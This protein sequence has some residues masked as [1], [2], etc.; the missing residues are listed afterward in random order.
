MITI[1]PLTKADAE[2]YREIRLEMLESAP[3]AFSSDYEQNKRSSLR[4]FANRIQTDE[5]NFIIGAFVNSK[6]VGTGGF[7]RE[8]SRKLRHR[9]HV[10]GV[11]VK[12]EERGQG[13]ARKICQELI[14]RVGR[15]D[16]L[17]QI[18]IA[19][20]STNQAAKRLYES[21]G[22]VAYG[23]APKALKIEDKY[24]DEDLMV[25]FLDEARGPGSGP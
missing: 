3:E 24:H 20:T 17:E 4:D 18:H 10:W 2:S 25:L 11:F 6:M 5:D 8:S 14:A 1:R 13:I 23:K 19:V 12:Q 21:M 7:Y 16:G 9:G 15:V 22:F